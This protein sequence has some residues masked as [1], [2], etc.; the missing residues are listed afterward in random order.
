MS[1]EI[2]KQAV[3]KMT[4][5]GKLIE[6]NFR[7]GTTKDGRQYESANFT[8]RTEQTYEDGHVEVDEIPISIFATQF[9]ST[10]A[11]HPGYRGIQELKE[12]K[13]IQQVGEAEADRVR[14]TAANVREN[15]FVSRSGQL[16]NGWQINTPFIGTAGA[17]PDIAIFNINIFIMDMHDEI[18]REGNPTGRLVIKGGIVQY[19][20]TLDVVEF[21][22]EDPDK[23]NYISRNWEVNDTVNAGGHIRVT[24]RE[25]KTSA[26]SGSWGEALP[27]TSTQYVRELIITRGSDFGFEEDL[28]YD[29]ADIKRAFNER[30][31][32][33]EQLQINAK[34]PKANPQAGT[35]ASKY[36]WA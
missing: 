16:V 32:R 11:P 30:K 27:D 28:A 5:V 25:V 29:P 17:S 7:S 33:I 4:I 24:T 20:G 18:D 23:I 22:V 15:N 12:L 1:L 26:E 3:N 21:I 13:T 19:G 36:S 31:A 35:A 8:V 9:T 6:T 2:T 34:Q 10:G 14:M